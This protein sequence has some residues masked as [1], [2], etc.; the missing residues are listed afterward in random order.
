MALTA[1]DGSA[2]ISTTEYSL[3]NAST[4]LTLKTDQ[5]MMQ[6]WVDFVNLAAGDSYRLRFK[7]KIRSASSAASTIVDVTI[8]GPQA[9][10]Y[11]LPSFIVRHGWDVTLLKVTGTDRTIE[12]SIEVVVVS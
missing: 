12:W 2:S 7:R 11:V 4:T 10:P 1:Y 5:G 6:G 3:P 9:A 8:A